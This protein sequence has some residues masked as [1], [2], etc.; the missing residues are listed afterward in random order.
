MC[1]STWL[2]AMKYRLVAFVELMLARHSKLMRMVSHGRRVAH[3]DDDVSVTLGRRR[4][5]AH[6]VDG[7][8]GGCFELRRRHGVPDD[9][10]GRVARFEGILQ[11]QELTGP[12]L[13][14]VMVGR[15]RV[16]DVR[17]DD[18]DA[19]REG[20][21]IGRRRRSVQRHVA[22]ALLAGR[23]RN[24]GTVRRRRRSIE[25][26]VT[27]ASALRRQRRNGRQPLVPVRVQRRIDGLELGVGA[28]RRRDVRLI[29]R[30]GA[31][32]QLQFLLVWRRQRLLVRLRF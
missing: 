30:P 15:R 23:A 32:G 8:D 21:R 31:H 24:A 14:V 11:R 12:R 7:S 19:G 13:Q 16:D 9:G 27:R 2:R 3:R 25:R 17:V 28:G 1:Q 22:R 6:V 26:Q 29:V 10:T 20:G 18:S 5:V 4:I